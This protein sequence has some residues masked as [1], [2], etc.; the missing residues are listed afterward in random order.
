MDFPTG[1]FQIVYADPPWSFKNY[2][3]KT[4]NSNADHHYPCMNMEDIKKLPVK[5][6]ADKDCV[7]FMW[8]TDPL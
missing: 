1:K 5:D 6:L 8:C 3:N 2:N 7:L 4:S